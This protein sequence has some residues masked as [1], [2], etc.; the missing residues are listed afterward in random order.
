[1][2]LHKTYFLIRFSDHAIRPSKNCSHIRWEKPY[3]LWRNIF[4]ASFLQTDTITP[5]FISKA[6]LYSTQQSLRCPGGNV[7]IDLPHYI[8]DRTDR[9]YPSLKTKWCL[10]IPHRI[11]HLSQSNDPE[12]LPSSHGPRGSSQIK[13]TSRRIT[14]IHDPE[15]RSSH[16]GLF[17]ATDPSKSGAGFS[18]HAPNTT[19]FFVLT[20]G[21]GSTIIFTFDTNFSTFRSFFVKVCYIRSCHHSNVFC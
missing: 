7:S 15:T 8:R 21:R 1:M 2:V 10:S 12:T 4:T 17:Q 19:H 16:Q 20:M 3:P 11:T 6:N 5:P 18:N 13:K 14:F 9:S